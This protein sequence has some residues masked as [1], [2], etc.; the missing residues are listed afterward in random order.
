MDLSNILAIA[1]KPDLSELVSRTK[2]GAIVMNLTTKQKYPVFHN[3]RISSLG[4][5]RIFTNNGEVPLS[6]VMASLK[7]HNNG[8]ATAFDPKKEESAKLFAELEQVLPEYDRDRVHSSD[9][10]KLFSWYNVLVNADKLN[11]DEAPA[12]MHE[13]VENKSNDKPAHAQANNTAKAT[14]K[15]KATPKRTTTAKKA[16]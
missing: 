15:A 6:D 7:K 5:I 8:A 9:V 12:E 4:E 3:D 14:T 13:V 1:G 16:I 2:N 10:K 11:D